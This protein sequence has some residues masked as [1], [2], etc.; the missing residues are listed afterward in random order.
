MIVGQHCNRIVASV[1]PDVSVVDAAKIMRERSLGYLVV[2]EQRDERRFPI[3][4]LT[5][6]DIVVH[7]VGSAVDPR[8]LLVK[9]I[10]STQPVLAHE[11]DDFMELVRGMRT[12]GIRR[13]PVVDHMGTLVGIVA[14]DDVLA[15]VS[16]MLD[17]LCG[18]VCN[19]QRME[20]RQQQSQAARQ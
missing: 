12:A 18:A 4:V 15:I 3:G 17:H 9:D 20:R 16:Q 13:V 19:E 8:T 11:D 14:L 5:D 1:A 10:M 7:V 2:T 6:R